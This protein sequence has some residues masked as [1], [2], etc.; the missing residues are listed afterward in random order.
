MGQPWPGAGKRGFA[1]LEF[2]FSTVLSADITPGGFFVCTGASLVLG[3][4][5]AFAHLRGGAS[6]RGFAFTVALMPAIVQLVIML[7]NG[8]LGTGVAV[9]GAFSLVRFR[10]APGTAEEIGT[11]FLA[12]AVGLATGMGYV[13]LAALFLLVMGLASALFA[14]LLKATPEGER[15][16]LVT[17]PEA[18]DSNGLFDD[19]FDRFTDGAVLEKVKTTAMGSLY[20]LQYRIRLR[21]EEEIR[22][23]LDEIRCRNGN[24]EVSCARPRPRGEQL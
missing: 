17:I 10:S 8:N 4:A 19:V 3:G 5:L 11:L 2:L 13:G 7:V 23:M 18:L 24:L 21:R 22:P 6:S 16:L 9:A 1:V 20:Q 15:T 12:M 14:R